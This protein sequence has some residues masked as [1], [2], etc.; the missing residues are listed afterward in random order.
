MVGR[1]LPFEQLMED[2]DD[3]DDDDDNDVTNSVFRM[4]HVGCRRVV[5]N[6]SV[7]HVSAQSAEVLWSSVVL[8]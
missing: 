1:V 7:V 3:G 5:E 4:K 2:D 8:C 6:Y